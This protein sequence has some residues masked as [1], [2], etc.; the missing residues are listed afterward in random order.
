MKDRTLDQIIT[1][2]ILATVLIVS[3]LVV[4]YAS[5]QRGYDKG[6]HDMKIETVVGRTT[7]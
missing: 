4:G 5:Y 6:W 2:L 1:N 3:F 7:K